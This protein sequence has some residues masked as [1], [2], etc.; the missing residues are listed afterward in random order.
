MRVFLL[1]VDGVGLGSD[2]PAVNPLVLARMPALRSLLGG[3]PLTRSAVPYAEPGLRVVPTDPRLGVRGLPQSATGQTAIF[4]G[5]NGPAAIGRHLNGYPT[6][7]LKALLGADSIF[8][9]VQ[10][11]GGRAT[12]LNAFPPPFFAWVE[13]GQ[14]LLKDRRY[15]PS[16]S[17]VAGLAAGIHVF[18]T[19]EQLKAGEA[20]GFDIDHH[21]LRERGYDLPPADPAEAGRRAARIAGANSFTLYEH[22]LTDKAG[23]ACDQAEAITVLERFD[24]FVGGVLEA[25]PE[26]LLLMITSDHGNVEDLSV[27][28]HTYNDVATILKGPG[29]ETAAGRIQSLTDITPAIIAVLADPRSFRTR[30][31]EPFHTS[32]T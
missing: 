31:N 11:A 9:Q 6:P 7:N 5:H 29:A 21:I 28:T 20:V 15:R 23:H 24:A 25:M 22:F 18:R 17:T 8:K 12:F 27:K 3:R 4:S 13:A 10:A 30:N 32:T 26:D 16:A 1:F 2:E 14:P 19:L